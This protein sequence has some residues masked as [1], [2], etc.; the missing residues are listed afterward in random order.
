ML[1]EPQC[2]LMCV[3][4]LIYNTLKC[5]TKKLFIEVKETQCFNYNKYDKNMWKIGAT[6]TK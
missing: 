6:K 2:Y 1:T 5:R 4:E 3:E